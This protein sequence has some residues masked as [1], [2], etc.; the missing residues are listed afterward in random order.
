MPSFNKVIIMGNLVRDPELRYTPSG[1]AVA[2]IRIAINRRRRTS[3]G[4]TQQETTFVDITA[5]GRHAETISQRFS[6]SDPIFI[7]GRLA[8]DEWVGKDGVRRSKLHVVLESFRFLTPPARKA[9]PQQEAPKPQPPAEKETPPA[10]S[11]PPPEE[12][13]IE[14]NDLPF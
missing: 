13:G 1:Q 14:F 6:K 3:G 12:P 4:Q 10:P 5:W 2:D 7:E 11:E 8:R 9:E